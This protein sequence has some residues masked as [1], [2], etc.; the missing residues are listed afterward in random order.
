MDEAGTA[1]AAHRHDDARRAPKPV[2]HAHAHLR[3]D[4]DRAALCAHAARAVLAGML[5]RR[6]LRRRHALPQGRPVGA[7]RAVA[8]RRAQHPLPDAAAWLECRRL[9]QLCRQRRALLRAAGG[10]GGHRRLPCVRLSQLGG[11]HARLDGCGDRIR[12]AVRGDHLLHR[13]HLRYG[14]AEIQPQVLRRSGAATGKGRR[15]HHR[16]QGHGRCL[17]AARRARTGAGAETRSRP[18]AALPYA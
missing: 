1:R 10:Q 7:S 4:R 16:H 14:A 8:R 5:G 13:R 11:Q 15:A 12:G 9:H 2:R 3:H 17:Q 18:A 6:H